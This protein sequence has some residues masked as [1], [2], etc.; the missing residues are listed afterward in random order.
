MPLVSTG[1]AESAVGVE[2]LLFSGD[3]TRSLSRVG[4]GERDGGTSGGGLEVLSLEIDGS[5][6]GQYLSTLE[7]APKSHPS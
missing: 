7:H 2:L 4:L 6:N 5:V 3:F 1:I